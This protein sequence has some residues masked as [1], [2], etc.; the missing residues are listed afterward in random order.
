MLGIS[1]MFQVFVVLHILVVLVVD[2]E[3]KAGFHLGCFMHPLQYAV[4]YY[5]ARIIRW[6]FCVIYLGLYASNSKGRSLILDSG[7]PASTS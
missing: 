6:R 5:R 3:L 2:I 4:K 7:S 1:F